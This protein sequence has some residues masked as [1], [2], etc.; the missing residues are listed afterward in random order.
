MK[1]I[2]TIEQEKEV[3]ELYKNNNTIGEI[4]K[5]YNVSRSPIKK[6]LKRNNV[7]QQVIK[8]MIIGEKYGII[9]VVSNAQSKNGRRYVWGQ[10]ECDGNIREY[11]WHHLKGGRIVS[12]GCYI[13]KIIKTMNIKSKEYWEEKHPLFCKIEKIRNN[14]NGIGIEVR[15]K[16]SDCKKWFSPHKLQIQNRIQAIEKPNRFEENNF[17]CSDNC[18]KNCILFGLKSNS[19]IYNNL[20]EIE[21]KSLP[22]E[23]NLRNWREEV[24]KQQ[25][26]KEGYNFCEMCGSTGNLQSH[27]VI[28]KKLDEFYALDPDNGIICCDDCHKRFHI[29]GCSTGVLS[30]KKCSK[31]E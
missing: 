20:G 4:A 28:P 11:N 21:G 8:D 6:A 31:A 13:K 23:S 14:K 2:L 18:K 24:F 15:C 27:H 12:C 3:C 22:S 30:H 10:C 25:L 5:I 17:Y 16:N 1:K 26:E 9:T 19:V 29:D 7:T